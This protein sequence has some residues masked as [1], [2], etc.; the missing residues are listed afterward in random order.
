MQANI[1]LGLMMKQNKS[2]A[3]V[4]DEF[5][6]TSGMVTIEDILEEI[7][8]EIEDEHDTESLDERKIT[9]DCFIFSGRLEIDYLNSKYHFDIPESDEYETIAGFILSNF[10]NIPKINESIE[11]ERYVF[12]IL[13]SSQTRIE[14]VQM[15]IK[16]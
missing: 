2:V 15:K 7:L 6:G 12:K 3:V 13:K 5:G 9:E 1:L 14:L 16:N 8:G 4:V 11:T 10:R